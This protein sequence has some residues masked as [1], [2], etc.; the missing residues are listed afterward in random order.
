[1]S[2]ELA[3]HPLVSVGAAAAAPAPL[4]SIGSAMCAARRSCTRRRRTGN[5]RALRRCASK[6]PISAA[7]VRDPP[8]QR[9]GK[10]GGGE[11]EARNRDHNFLPS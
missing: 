4:V 7:A 1:M 8:P 6:G 10:P 11:R 9:I 3:T 2:G 5:V